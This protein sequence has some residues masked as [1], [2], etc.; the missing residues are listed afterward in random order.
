MEFVY[1]LMTNSIHIFSVRK[2]V[3]KEISIGYL[4]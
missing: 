4:P 3:V 2:M 1:Q